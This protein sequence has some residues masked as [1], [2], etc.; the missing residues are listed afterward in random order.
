MSARE[1]SQRERGATTAV[2][3]EARGPD[4][5]EERALTASDLLAEL[6]EEFLPAPEDNRFVPAVADGKA[7]LAAV[8]ALAAEQHRIVPS[9]QRS[10]LLLAARSVGSPAGE[11]FSG[12][13]AG[14]TVARAALP[15]LAAACG[16]DEAAV[17]RYQPM[18]GCQAYPAYVTWLA[19]NADPCDALIALVANF[20]AF[21]QYCA[22][23]ARALRE[24][25]GLP[26]EACAFFDLFATPPEGEDPNVLAAVEIVQQRSLDRARDHARLLQSYE[27]L[28]WNTL[29]EV[30]G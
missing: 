1:G 29:A 20:T 23:L 5:R 2:R 19:L 27:L 22:T 16:L 3:P 15:A 17:R 7:P 28:F 9:D 25:Y 21:G 30:S 26:G 13:A 4:R 18:P 8:G 12:L 11:F 10:F 24:H 6:R 14:E